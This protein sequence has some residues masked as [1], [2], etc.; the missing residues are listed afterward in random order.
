MKTRIL[1]IICL[2]MILSAGSLFSQ[3]SSA[4]IVLGASTSSVKLSDFNN[5]TVAA[6]KGQGIMGYEGGLYAKFEFGPIYLKPMV[7]AGYQSGQLNINYQD[8]SM[9][10]ADFKDGKLVVPVLA[11]IR[12]LHIAGIEAGPVYN[13]MF[14]TSG[15]SDPSINLQK[16]GLGYRVGANVFLG[17]LTVGLAYQG[18]TNMSSSSATTTFK[19]PDELILNVSLRLTRSNK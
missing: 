19:S 15:T 5:T 9:K 16:S 11:G 7:L 3:S 13:W 14:M 10:Q 1:T 6:A 8:G 2:S 18:L 12:L 17:R 4:G